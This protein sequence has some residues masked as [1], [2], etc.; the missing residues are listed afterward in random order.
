VVHASFPDAF[1]FLVFKSV[2][3]HAAVGPF[4]PGSSADISLSQSA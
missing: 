4:V 3:V 1:G 2:E